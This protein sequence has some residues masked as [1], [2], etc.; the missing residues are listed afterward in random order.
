MYYCHTN[1][2]LSS[3]FYKFLLTEINGETEKIM[4]ILSVLRR[5]ISNRLILLPTSPS[6]TWSFLPNL[7]LLQSG[8]SSAAGSL[9]Q[10]AYFHLC[11][12]HL[13][14]DLTAHYCHVGKVILLP[15][16]MHI[17]SSSSLLSQ[18]PFVRWFNLLAAPTGFCCSAGLWKSS[19][20]TRDGKQRSGRTM[21]TGVQPPSL[22]SSVLWHLTH[23]FIPPD[24]TLFLVFSP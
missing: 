22:G 4:D 8:L 7:L 10:T 24:F 14:G 17:P 15:L 13:S 12:S 19:T 23:S 11:S 9:L 16:L 20:S 2:H 3:G 21:M 6:Q 5:N 1:L 18:V